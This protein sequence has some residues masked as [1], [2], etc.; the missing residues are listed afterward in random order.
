M[1]CY[2]A[3]VPRATYVWH[4]HLSTSA[5]GPQ[6]SGGEEGKEREGGKLPHI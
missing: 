2:N 5:P 6:R 1:I 4:W 3:G